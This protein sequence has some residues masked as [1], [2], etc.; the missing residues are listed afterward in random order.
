MKRKKRRNRKSYQVMVKEGKTARRAL[1]GMRIF[2]TKREAKEALRL[3]KPY[4]DQYLRMSLKEVR[5]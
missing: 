5:G 2:S 3:L 1:K 4:E